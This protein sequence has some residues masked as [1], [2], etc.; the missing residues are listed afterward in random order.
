MKNRYKVQNCHF[1]SIVDRC[2]FI[3]HVACRVYKYSGVQQIKTLGNYVGKL[4]FLNY[5]VNSYETIKY[6]YDKKTKNKIKTIKRIVNVFNIF[7]FNLLL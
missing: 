2:S 4:L 5:P 1:Y 6:D 7:S 3:K